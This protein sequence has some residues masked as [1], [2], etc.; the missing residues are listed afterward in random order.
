MAFRHGRFAEITVN[1]KDLS[2]FCNSADLSIDVDTADTTT[3]TATW[4]TALTGVAG[5]KIDLKGEYDPTA[6]TGPAAVLTALIGA[7]PFEV[8]VYPGGN[9][10]GQLSRTFDAILTS[11]QESSPVGGTVTFSAGLMV[12]GAVSFDTVGA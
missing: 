11:Y 5:G 6:T 2:T 1:T 10:A 8:T 9:S 7:D 4:K 12:T 3:F